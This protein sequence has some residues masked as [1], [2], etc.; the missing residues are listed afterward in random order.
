MKKL[1][2]MVFIAGLFFLVSCTQKTTEME[3]PLLNKFETPHGVPPFELIKVEHFV[4]AYIEAIKQ[5]DEEIVAI[6]NN[7]EVP[8][9][10]NTIEALEFSGKLLT[11]VDF[12][13]N[14]L[15]QSLTSDEMQKVAQEVA[16]LLSKHGDDI[17]LFPAKLDGKGT[18]SRNVQIHF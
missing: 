9:F 8:S 17:S 6:V 18:G 11:Q 1:T 4:P 3:N 5:H 7:P 16:P 14:N 2:L 15:N 12:T 10:T 13:F